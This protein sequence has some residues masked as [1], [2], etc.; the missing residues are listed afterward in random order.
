MDRYYKQI[1]DGYII[2]V[3][4]G[5]GGAEITQEE[6]NAIRF[7]IRSRPTA[8]EGYMYKLKADLTWEKVEAPQ[9]QEVPDREISDKAA[10]D[11]ILGGGRA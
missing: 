7:L 5:S 2:T 1:K 8:E 4:I 6:Y 3:G 10:L 9:K 11:I